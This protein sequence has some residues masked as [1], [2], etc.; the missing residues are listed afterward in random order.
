MNRTITHAIGV[1]II[2]VFM[3][4][5]MQVVAQLVSPVQQAK[6]V[7]E[8]GEAQIVKAF[9]DPD[10]WIRHDLWVETDFDT[11]GD[12]KPDRMHVDVTRPRQTETEGL[13]LPVVYN[14]SPY[15]AGTAGNSRDYFWKV[16]HE[17][18]ATPPPLMHPPERLDS[19][20]LPLINLNSIFDP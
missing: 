8:N 2:S 16:N 12:G 11:D 7:F 15:F 6:P 10:M 20:L 17:I 9:E 3:L 18:G 5:E 14:S 1:I 19:Q 4:A 13:K